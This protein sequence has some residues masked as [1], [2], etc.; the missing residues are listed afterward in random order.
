MSVFSICDDLKIVHTLS[1][2]HWQ[3]LETLRDLLIPF[4]NAVKR[5]EGEEY[6]KFRRFILFYSA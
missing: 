1:P 2:L 4:A 3:M 5:L 6:V